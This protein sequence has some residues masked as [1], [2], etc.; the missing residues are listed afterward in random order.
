MALIYLVR[1]GQAGAGMSGYGGAGDERS[2][3]SRYDGLTDLGRRQA[4]TVGES[5]ARRLDGG[6]RLP[7]ICGPLHRQH[8]TAAAIARALDGAE[9]A[10]EPVTD[11]AWKELDS[12]AVVV[13]WLRR[14]PET[15]AR[16]KAATGH[17]HHGG[18]GT[19]DAGPVMRE[20][21]AGAIG[22]WVGGESFRQFR[23][24]VL[25]G[26]TRAAASARQDGG[27]VVATSAGV[28]AT[29]TAAVSGLSRQFVP[30]LMGRVYNASVTVIKVADEPRDPQAGYVGA[31]LVSF[32]EYAHLDRA[33]ATGARP[34]LTLL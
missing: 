33:D 26:L 21:L 24:T 9:S 30:P 34:E 12:D 15:A 20:V 23:A 29:C 13:P 14:N 27:A 28:I 17:T 16:L 2:V 11:T 18:D 1:H 22:E 19:H 8:D 25:S 6:P 32:N 4:A 31:E 10:A 3:E 5:L 7:V